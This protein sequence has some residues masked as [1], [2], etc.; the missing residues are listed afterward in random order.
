MS[1]LPKDLIV[2]PM[3]HCDDPDEC[4]DHWEFFTNAT[5]G[6]SSPESVARGSHL[7]KAEMDAIVEKVTADPEGARLHRI[8]AGYWRTGRKVGRTVY[9]MVGDEPSDDD[10]LIG[11]MDQPAIATALVSQHNEAMNDVRGIPNE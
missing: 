10:M 7:T 2:G 8:L 11:T 9:C 4:H 3:C 5:M 1:D 6:Y